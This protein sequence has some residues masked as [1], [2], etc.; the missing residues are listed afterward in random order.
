MAAL[1]TEQFT[2]WA[3]ADDLAISTNSLSR[4][5][6]AIEIAKKWSAMNGIVVNLAKSAIM[7]FRVD[8]RTPVRLPPIFKGIPVV[9]QQKYL[10]LLFDDCLNFRLQI[11]KID[12]IQ[13]KFWKVLRYSGLAKLPPEAKVHIWNVIFWAQ[14]QYGNVF[15]ANNPAIKQSL[16]K[17]MYGAFKAIL[18]IKT[19]PTY[20]SLAGLT[21]DMHF[22]EYIHL[23]HT[24]TANRLVNRLA[25]GEQIDLHRQIT[26]AQTLFKDWVCSQAPSIIHAN[27]DQ[28][29]TVY[30][31]QV[32]KKKCHCG[33]TV[34]QQH[35]MSNLCWTHTRES[36]ASAH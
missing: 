10:G 8:R 31:N 35:L 21:L 13:R 4:L 15:F 2:C 7:E 16:A 32:A 30:S 20:D 6:K 11:D 3:F 18:S 5:A 27:V 28:L 22:E 23:L 34:T 1:N 12:S 33:S 14:A 9:T 36:L 17:L 26:M 29:V 19:N 25:P 24:K